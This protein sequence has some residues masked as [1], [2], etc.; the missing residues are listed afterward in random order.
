MTS[1]IGE[2]ISLKQQQ[3]SIPSNCPVRLL[4]QPAEEGA[5]GAVR[6]VEAGGLTKST[7]STACLTSP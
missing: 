1:L 6:M 2:A 7:A 5:L 3:S 4:F